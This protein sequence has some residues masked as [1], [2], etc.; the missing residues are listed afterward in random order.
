MCIIDIAPFSCSY[1]CRCLLLLLL[2]NLAVLDYAMAITVAVMVTV[3]VVT[4]VCCPCV[5]CVYIVVCCV[6]LLVAAARAVL[7]IKGGSSRGCGLLA[8]VVFQVLV[9]CSSFG[10][11]CV[12]VCRMVCWAKH[13]G[14]RHK[15]SARRRL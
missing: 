5:S 6:G 13:V 11:C 14:R 9:D 1:C 2:I 7:A 15:A 10:S 3:S 4:G 8:V 12:A